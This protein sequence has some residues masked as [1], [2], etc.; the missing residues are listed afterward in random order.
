[1]SD[2]LRPPRPPRPPYFGA[3][4]RKCNGTGLRTMDTLRLI[5]RIREGRLSLFG[6]GVGGWFHRSMGESYGG[7]GRGCDS[8]GGCTSGL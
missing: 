6:G 2:R 7:C 8:G 5:E 3:E 4:S 1:M